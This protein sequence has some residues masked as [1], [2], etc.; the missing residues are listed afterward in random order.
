MTPTQRARIAREATGHTCK[1]LD[2]KVIIVAVAQ[3]GA[4]SY[5]FDPEKNPSHWK[6]LVEWLADRVFAGTD[7]R[8]SFQIE[9]LSAIHRRDVS[10][11]KQLA[12]DIMEQSND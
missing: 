2:G 5:W 7:I 8:Y 11:L 6:L 1:V 10:K 12:L 9:L 3:D 4:G